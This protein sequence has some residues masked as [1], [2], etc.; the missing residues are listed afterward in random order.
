MR[1]RRWDSKAWRLDFLTSTEFRTD[2]FEAYYNA[3]LHRPDDSASLNS[4]VF[5]NL[6]VASVRVVFE[7]SLEFF[8]NG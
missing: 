4:Y 2:D 8:I 1:C 6:D 3:L 5:S 7:A